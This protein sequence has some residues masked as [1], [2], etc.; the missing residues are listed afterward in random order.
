MSRLLTKRDVQLY[1][2]SVAILKIDVDINANRIIVLNRNTFEV[3][4]AMCLPPSKVTIIQLP[5]TYGV[6]GKLMVAIVDDDAQ[7]NA[8]VA[9]GVNCE[10]MSTPVDMSQ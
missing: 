4:A 9:D 1:Q 3:L 7:Y 5:L 2:R 6:S 10:F 8:V